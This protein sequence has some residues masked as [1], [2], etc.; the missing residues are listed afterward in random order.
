M[1]GIRVRE[2]RSSDAE[3]LARLLV[4]FNGMPTTAAQVRGRLERMR[5]V[6]FPVLA[7]LD[8][9]P[10]GFASLRLVHYLGEDVPFAEISDLFVR[11]PA[12]RRGVAR[13]LLDELERR[14]R[15]AEATG[16]NVV[17]GE[18]NEAALALYRASGFETFAVAMQR[19]FSDF[20]PFKPS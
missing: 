1:G 9:E 18:D 10:V 14:A 3:S 6:E 8:A 5:G 12:R 7:D 13:A 20:R 2:V 11:E 17:T 4:E 19:W 16:W 15:A